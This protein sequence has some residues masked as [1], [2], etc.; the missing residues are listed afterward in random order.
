MVPS[1]CPIRRRIIAQCGVLVVVLSGL[2]GLLAGPVHAQVF[3]KPGAGPSEKVQRFQFT[4]DPNT[5]ETQLLPTAPAAV[6]LPLPWQVEDLARVPEL[7]LQ[8]PGLLHKNNAEEQIALAAA[9]INHLNQKATDHFVVLLRQ[10]RSDLA[11]LP[12]MMG[13]ACRQ[14]RDLRWT[15]GQELALVRLAML[16]PMQVGKEVAP[17]SVDMQPALNAREFWTRYTAVRQ[18]LLRDVPPGVKADAQEDARSRVAAMMQVLAPEGQEVQTTLV[19][20]LVGLMHAEAT[21]ALARLAVFSRDAEVRRPALAALQHRPR[22]DYTDVLL[23][24]L[25]Y[26]WPA[27]NRNASEA[28]TQLRRQDLVP[29]LVAILDEPDPRAPISIEVSG[30]PTPAVREVVKVNHHRNCLLCHA[31]GNTTD[32]TPEIVTGAVPIPDRPLTPQSQGYDPQTSPDLLVRIDVTYLRQDFSML[33][34]VSNAAPWPA[35]QRFDFLVRTRAVTSEEAQSYRHWGRNQPADYVAPHQQAVLASLRSLTGR[36]IAEPS[37]Q[38]WR[39][40]LRN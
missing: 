28:I 5:P 15:F 12:F 18:N 20:H 26:P 3:S 4:I 6:K 2:V 19:Q 13:E 34:P 23:A 37:A 16:D 17:N 14:N 9:R 10:H 1:A 30:K 24:G 39:D 11:G 7:A 36:D 33:Q 25:R 22:E 27:F 40:A 35:M 21:R 38:A 29:Q 32:M 8:D 31:P